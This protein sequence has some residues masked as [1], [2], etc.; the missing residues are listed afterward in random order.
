MHFTLEPWEEFH[1]ELQHMYQTAVK[2]QQT[3][4]LVHIILW[5]GFLLQN[6]GGLPLSA[7]NQVVIVKDAALKYIVAR[8]PLAPFKCCL[9]D[10]TLHHRQNSFLE[11]SKQY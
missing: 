9:K 6:N 5:L 10:Y 1:V 8:Y 11:K 2:L 7:P 4:L 3:C